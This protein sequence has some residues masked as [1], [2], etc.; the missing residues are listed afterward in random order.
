MNWW[1]AAARGEIGM[2][3]LP[4]D[5][6]EHA[7]RSGE[8]C[9]TERDWAQYGGVGIVMNTAAMIERVAP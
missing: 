3:Q 4:D 9:T 6:W 7:K 8:P 1:T 2:D 5:W